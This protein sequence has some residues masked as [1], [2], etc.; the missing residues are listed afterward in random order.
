MN[1]VSAVLAI[2]QCFEKLPATAV[3]IRPVALGENLDRYDLVVVFLASMR[4]FLCTYTLGSLWALHAAPK[5]VVAFDDWQ[6]QVT[7]IG[8]R[9]AW[10]EWDKI[11]K[12]NP[13]GYKD[14]E[15][16]P[17]HD[18]PIRNTLE[19]LATAT[20]PWNVL[21]PVYL[22]GDLAKLGVPAEHVFP[23][24]PASVFKGHYGWVD[25]CYDAWV[26]RKKAWVMAALH[27]HT[28]WAQKI[29]VS[30]PID[31]YGCRKLKQPRMP[32]AQLFEVYKATRGMLSPAYKHVSSGWWRARWGFA[33]D[34]LNV[35]V[36]DTREMSMVD[37]KAYGYTAKEIE[38][39]PDRELFDLAI[40]Q[41]EAYYL[42]G[43]TYDSLMSQL[44]QG[45]P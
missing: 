36:G 4:G 40:C 13:F 41:R 6:T 3:E 19:I 8:I 20:W 26:T 31:V 25:A 45:M 18:K 16:L 1:Y 30:W 38:A 15:N 39:M 10:R 22:G 24:N 27:D 33:A 29:G 14:I 7:V 44:I 17:T 32:E 42:A 35:A 23:Y 5:V 37:P 2:K 12:V 34:A 9:N 11:L 28:K 43:G 21:M